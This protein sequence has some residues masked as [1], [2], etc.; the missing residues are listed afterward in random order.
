MT[1]Q[2]FEVV[3]KGKVIVLTINERCEVHAGDVR[4]GRVSYSK[5]RKGARKWLAL[6]DHD[7]TAGGYT[8]RE[9]AASLF[10]QVV[11]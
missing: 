11:R 10:Y 6:G 5:D 3:R 2:R 8:A 7:K 1:P 9:A 4:I